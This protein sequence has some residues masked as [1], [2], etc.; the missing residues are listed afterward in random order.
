MIS[1]RGRLER[2]AAVD[3]TETRL[4]APVEPAGTTATTNTAPPVAADTDVAAPLQPFTAATEEWVWTGEWAFGAT[5]TIDDTVPARLPFHYTWVNGIASKPPNSQQER[6]EG[7][8]TAEPN[9]STAERTASQESNE[10]RPPPPPAAVAEGSAT[11]LPLPL[12]PPPLEAK[13]AEPKEAPK[14]SMEVEKPAISESLK[15]EDAASETPPSKTID[16]QGLTL[17]ASGQW[18]GSFDTVSGRKGQQKINSVMEHFILTWNLSPDDSLR[19]ILPNEELNTN[20]DAGKLLPHHVH[21]TGRGENHYGDF[22]FVGSLDTTTCVLQ[23][24]KR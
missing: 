8:S 17:P 15:A 23:C 24:Q 2:R 19:T 18:K 16:F 11:F 10:A 9:Q 1:L 20:P 21:V 22:E 7:E 6:A 3:S 12:P 4:L 13:P 5:T 14:H